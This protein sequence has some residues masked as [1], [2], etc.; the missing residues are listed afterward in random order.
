MP[1]P[2]HWGVRFDL[3]VIFYGFQIWGLK[4][5][6]TSGHTNRGAGNFHICLRSNA[7]CINRTDTHPVSIVSASGW[8]GDP[9]GLTEC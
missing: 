4:T 5:L 1:D 2:H 7:R 3:D 9:N 6:L 8:R